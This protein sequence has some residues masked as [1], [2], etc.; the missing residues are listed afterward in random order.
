MGPASWG[1]G[2][3][4]HDRRLAVRYGDP[5]IAAELARKTINNHLEEWH[6]LS[7]AIYVEG[8]IS[9]YQAQDVFER[10]QNPIAR[11]EADDASGQ[12]WNFTTKVRKAEGH[13][14][15]I[16]I[17]DSDNKKRKDDFENKDRKVIDFRTRSP[18]AEKIHSRAPIRLVA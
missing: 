3:V 4:T 15:T 1:F 13:F 11:I 7:R 5:H 18:L 6:A 10:A 8:E 12:R 14:V 17:E 2:G 9:G 16:G